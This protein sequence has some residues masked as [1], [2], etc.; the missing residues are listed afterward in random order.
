MNKLF[1]LYRYLAQQSTHRTDE[2]NPYNEALRTLEPL[3]DAVRGVEQYGRMVKRYG[4]FEWEDAEHLKEFL[5]EQHK[6][7]LC[8]VSGSSLEAI[9]DFAT[10]HIKL[11]EID[12][13]IDALHQQKQ[14]MLK[15]QQE[16][17]E[18]LGDLD[19]HPF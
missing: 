15:E 2:D 16:Q 3:L 5:I 1:I 17:A 14:T 13:L 11:D 12:A 7:S 8:T 9:K 6:T 18:E 10:T 4:G 19:G